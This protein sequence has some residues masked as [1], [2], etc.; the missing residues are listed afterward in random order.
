MPGTVGVG[1]CMALRNCTER[2]VKVERLGAV[3]P[4]LV[5]LKKK[6]TGSQ[7][8]LRI[9]FSR[10]LGIDCWELG[11]YMIDITYVL[12]DYYGFNGIHRGY[13]HLQIAAP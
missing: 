3:S 12:K 8:E 13:A 5:P 7:L 10:R 2:D 9:E 6:T 11:L 4:Q 1:S